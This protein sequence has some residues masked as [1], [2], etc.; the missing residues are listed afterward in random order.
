VIVVT[1]TNPEPI[2]QTFRFPAGLPGYREP[3]TRMG[4]EGTAEPTADGGARVTVRS[5]RLA[6]GVRVRA[7]G[8]V[9]SD[10]A[11]SVEPGHERTVRIRPGGDGTRFSRVTLTALNLSTELAVEVIT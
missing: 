7:S 6:Y 9:C 3:A 8:M 10:D 1:L 4:I 11:F 2:S 5:R